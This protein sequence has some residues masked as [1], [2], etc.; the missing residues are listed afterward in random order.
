MAT[1]PGFLTDWPWKPLGSFK[2]VLLA[3]WVVHSVYCFVTSEESERDYT[4]FL[5]FPSLLFRMLHNQLWISYSR[6]R[7]A[8]GKS[9]IVD[10][11][12]E[13]EQVDRESNWDDQI[14]LNGLLYY[15]LNVTGVAS[16]L[17]AWRTDGVVMTVAIHAGPVEFLYYWLH[18]ALHHHYLYSRYH[19]HHHSSIVTEPITSVIHP[20]GEILA[21][22]SLFMIPVVTTLTTGTASNV[23]LFGYI[24]Y[25]D[26]MDNLGHCN[27]EFFPK[28]LFS[29][30]P[31]LKYLMYTPSFHS[32]HHTQF[33]TNY[34]L[35]MPFYDYIYGTV[36]KSSDT[37]YETS[38]KREE[39]SPDVVHLTHLI[40][41]ESVYY[42]RLGV[43]SWAS[44]PQNQ[45]WYIIWLMWPMTII[46]NSIFAQ[47]FISERN[48]MGKVKSQSWVIP[49]CK[50][51][52]LLKRQSRAINGLIEEAIL[53][54]EAKGVK[55]LSLGL[56]NQSEELNM[57]GEVYVQKYPK[58][59]MRLVDGSSLAAAIV[60]N[61]I[62]RGTTEVLLRANLNKVSISIASALTQRGIKVVTSCE[63]D[64]EKLMLATN[65]K[66]NLVMSRS[67]TQKIWLVGE[68]LRK[69]EQKKATK[70]TMFIPLSE[71]PP[72][73]FRRD[74]FYR[75]PPA[76]LAP[77]SFQNLH[78]C[79][80]WL[81][82]KA[83]S[84]ARVAGILHALEGWNVHECGET[85]LDTDKVWEAAVRHGFRLINDAG[86]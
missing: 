40:T 86:L 43:S 28:C 50:V 64:Y 33:R 4:N 14:L 73:K 54:A 34:S 45:K 11:P 65:S 2:Y 24:T 83:M 37:L 21:Y 16:R 60:M 79:E 74:C 58:T 39:E 31:P 47:T 70:G 9:R 26:V 8:K 55:V 7:T 52:Y 66:D 61:T 48:I 42:L 13:F 78:S 12:I 72:N 67:F 20:F 71:F 36:D 18:R 17:P 62:P 69:E 51:Q 56:C 46:I 3:P 41:P 29:I 38:L 35:F 6:H 32:L 1:T 49:K 75:H 25:I 15:V 85:M 63:D 81:P 57:N 27:F 77:P 5:I 10:K 76:M 80:N 53:D 82:R 59:K 44:M 68:G 19:S 22:F 23:S 84:A 30:F